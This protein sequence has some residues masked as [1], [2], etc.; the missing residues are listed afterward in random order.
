MVSPVIRAWLALGLR[1]LL[2]FLYAVFNT[3]YSLHVFQ[4]YISTDLNIIN[5]S[6][7]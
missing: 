3:Q 2:H 6:V 4:S 5:S 1:I 7:F